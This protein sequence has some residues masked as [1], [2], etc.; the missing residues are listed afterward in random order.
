MQSLQSRRSSPSTGIFQN[1]KCP[2][3]VEG[4]RMRERPETGR[5]QVAE[6]R[7]KD[8]ET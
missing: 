4:G 3:W 2:S 6:E 7:T 1:S 8:S 5:R